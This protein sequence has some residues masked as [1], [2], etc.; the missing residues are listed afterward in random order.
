MKKRKKGLNSGSI[1]NDTNCGRMFR[2]MRKHR[3][4]LDFVELGHLRRTKGWWVLMWPYPSIRNV[5][6]TLSEIRKELRENNMPY[7]VEHKS[8]GK[9][10]HFYRVVRTK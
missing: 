10:R 4:W 9:K 7:E 3:C 2:F 8:E 5:N 1:H 6:A